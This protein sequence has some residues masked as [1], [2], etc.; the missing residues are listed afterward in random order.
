MKSAQSRLFPAGK[1][2]PE[3]ITILSLGAGQESTALAL[4]ADDPGFRGR[5]TPGR[6]LCVISDV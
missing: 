5:W 1:R 2:D 6:Y 3:P 4:M